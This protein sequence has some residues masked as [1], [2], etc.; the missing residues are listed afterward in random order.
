M[1]NNG[2]KTISD[3]LKVYCK[4]FEDN[5][6]SLELARTSK[7]WQRTKH[8]NSSDHIYWSYVRDKII[9]IFLVYTFNQIA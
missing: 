3:D 2:I 7:I 9:L 8:I 5:F 4:V 6:G 1:N